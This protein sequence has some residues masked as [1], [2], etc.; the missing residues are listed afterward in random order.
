MLISIRLPKTSRSAW[1]GRVPSIEIGWAPRA[2]VPGRKGEIANGRS[3]ELQFAEVGLGRTAGTE[4]GERR[5]SPL[6]RPW[7]FQRAAVQVRIDD[8]H[9]ARLS[10]T[11][12]G[13]EAALQ[14]LRL[15]GGLMA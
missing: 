9:R 8:S 7:D 3:G 14:N 2:A 13:G 1:S 5:Q 10:M 12:A 15:Y 11:A 4:K 6:T